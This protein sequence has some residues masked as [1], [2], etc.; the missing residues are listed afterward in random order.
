VVG[1]TDYS[2]CTYCKMICPG[3]QEDMVSAGINGAFGAQERRTRFFILILHG[4]QYSV[5][6]A[7]EGERLVVLKQPSRARMCM[8]V[9][10]C[11][12]APC[13]QTI[14]VY[15]TLFVTMKPHKLPT[16]WGRGH[17]PTP[18]KRMD[19]FADIHKDGSMMSARNNACCSSTVTDMY[20][21]SSAELQSAPKHRPDESVSIL[22][23]I[24]R[25]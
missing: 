3:E 6:E 23:D 8:P 14:D 1:D 21:L 9:Y 5:H 20:G 13:S 7:D 19:E 24:L 25:Q 12:A 15:R 17:L 10:G 4:L 16:W 22:A 11:F 2:Q 18:N